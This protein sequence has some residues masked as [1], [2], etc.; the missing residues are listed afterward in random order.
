MWYIYHMYNIETSD[1]KCRG[2]GSDTC[3]RATSPVPWEYFSP[4]TQWWPADTWPAGLWE[5]LNPEMNEKQN[6][7]QKWEVS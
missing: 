1:M 4:L 2:S 5:L 7:W 3:I 6:A